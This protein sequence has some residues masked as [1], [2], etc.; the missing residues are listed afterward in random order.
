M[1]VSLAMITLPN[2]PGLSEPTDEEIRVCAYHLYEQSGCVPGR[3]LENWL[4]A[5]NYLCVSGQPA[6]PETHL[7]KRE[8]E[9]ALNR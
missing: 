1:G 4:E 8:P 7:A 9:L 5:R 2:E 6:K 3:D